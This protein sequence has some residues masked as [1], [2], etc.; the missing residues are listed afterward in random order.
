MVGDAIVVGTA[1][2]VSKD[3]LSVPAQRMLASNAL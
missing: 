1:A 2:A 3:A